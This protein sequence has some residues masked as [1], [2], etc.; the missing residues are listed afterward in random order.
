MAGACSA[1]P[2]FGPPVEDVAAEG[3]VVD[4]SMLEVSDAVAV[5]EETGDV[6]LLIPFWNRLEYPLVGE[7]SPCC[8]EFAAAAEL[9]ESEAVVGK[10][11]EDDED[12]MEEGE[13][14]MCTLPGR[15]SGWS[16]I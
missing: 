9:A 16:Y 13:E 2:G 14:E 10:R 1:E 4:V 12:A 11:D 8:D 6:G 5:S 7:M 15:G 3:P